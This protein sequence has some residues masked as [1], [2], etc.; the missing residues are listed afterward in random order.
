MANVN[1][2]RD[3]G[4]FLAQTAPFNVRR[5]K[6]DVENSPPKVPTFS[7]IPARR[8][9]TNG[10]AVTSPAKKTRAATNRD[11]FALLC[12]L[13]F[14]PTARANV[15]FSQDFSSS[16]D[17]KSYYSP[18]LAPNAGQWDTING[19]FIDNGALKF[20]HASGSQHYNFTRSTDF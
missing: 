5:P 14:P 8:M 17:V 10:R 9:A 4:T 11:L 15:I 3:R 6:V 7:D 19:G 2:Q 1:Y 18:Q 13:A 16:T 12:L 20:D